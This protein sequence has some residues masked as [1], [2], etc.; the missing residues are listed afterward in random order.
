MFSDVGHLPLTEQSWTGR[1]AGWG[2]PDTRM[3]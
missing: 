1:G 2:A 3:R